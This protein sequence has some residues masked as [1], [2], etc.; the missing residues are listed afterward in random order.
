MQKGKSHPVLANCSCQLACSGATLA[1]HLITCDQQSVQ[2]LPSFA[3]RC[4]QLSTDG[5]RFGMCQA[6][7]LLRDT[8]RAEK[9][10]GRTG[11]A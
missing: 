2:R 6:Q 1:A 8:G 7:H 5:V 3:C 9:G 4:L 10:R 11:A